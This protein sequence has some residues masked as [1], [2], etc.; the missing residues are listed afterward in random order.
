MLNQIIAEDLDIVIRNNDYAIY[1]AENVLLTPGGSEFCHSGIRLLQHIIRELTFYNEFQESRVN[2]FSIYCYQKDNVEKSTGLIKEIFSQLLDLDPFMR[3]KF[4]REEEQKIENTKSI[5]A[6]LENEWQPLHFIYGGATIVSRVFNDFINERMPKGYD[7]SAL[8]YEEAKSIIY[9]Y[10]SGMSVEKKSAVNLL[11][12]YH[13]S[14]IITPIFLVDLLITP[15]EYA[16]AVFNLN[17]PQ[18]RNSALYGR[19]FEIL[20]QEYFEP[21]TIKANTARRDFEKVKDEALSAVEYI[22]LHQQEKPGAPDL[23][24]ILKLGENYN[25][26][27]KSTLRMN[28]KAGKKDVNIEHASLKTIAAFLNSNGGVL[29]VGVRDDSS[30]EGIET[31]AFDNEDRFS[32]HFWNLLK[33][34]MGQDVSAFI[35]T[36]FHIK[37]GKTVFMVN[38]SKSTRPVFLRQS[39]FGEEFYIRVGPS[40]G[41]LEIS[42]ALKY[43]NERFDKN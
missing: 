11:V 13:L 27:F 40:S 26:E 36:S 32:L 14:G 35:Q 4:N 16:N 34:S 39:G 43:I 24:E 28:L 9:N 7:I 17:L 22:V 12:K 30:I 19:Y 38:C 25:V 42:E 5:L 37:D 3:K 23:D 8:S 41:K 33:S 21:P 6:E 1:H 2:C 31:D 15:S 20:Q 18:F 10:Y 29:L